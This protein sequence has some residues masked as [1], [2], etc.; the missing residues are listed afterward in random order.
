VPADL[1]ADV[2]V[3]ALAVAHGMDADL[4][5]RESRVVIQRLSASAVALTGEPVSM[6]ELSHDV[7]RA[8]ARYG[9][10]TVPEFEALVASVG[11]ALGEEGRAAVFEILVGVAEADGVVRTMEQT[12]LRHI[13]HAWGVGPP[14]GG[15]GEEGRTD[16][17]R[18]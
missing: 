7:E 6:A 9:R 8:V 17:G 11:G 12:L 15:A 4:D 3:V 16:E 5:P 10:L 18:V 2:T 1:L 14:D 13:A